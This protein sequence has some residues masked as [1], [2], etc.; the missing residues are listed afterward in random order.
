M[1]SECPV[2]AKQP[3]SGE[4]MRTATQCTFDFVQTK[5]TG[6][7]NNQNVRYSCNSLALLE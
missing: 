7:R 5:Q 1:C 6:I 2:Y 3:N 4:L